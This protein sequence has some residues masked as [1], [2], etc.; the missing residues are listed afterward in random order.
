[1]KAKKDIKWKNVSK[2]Q[3]VTETEFTV[4]DLTEGV[5]YEFRVAAENKA[6]VGQASKPSKAVKYGKSCL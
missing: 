5:E 3:T 1:M 4:P 6:G 2:G